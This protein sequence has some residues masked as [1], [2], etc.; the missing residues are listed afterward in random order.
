MELW[1][2]GVWPFFGTEEKGHRA[3]E[4][5]TC[6][7]LLFSGDLVKIGSAGIHTARRH[8]GTVPA[9]IGGLVSEMRSEG[10]SRKDKHRRKPSWNF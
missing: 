2:L 3:A 5:R 7:L 6:D 1:D 4:L 9:K 10:Q 8:K